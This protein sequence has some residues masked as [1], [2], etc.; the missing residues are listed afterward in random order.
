MVKWTL[1]FG[2][3]LLALL[4]FEPVRAGD[5]AREIDFA[6]EIRPLLADHCFHC[7]GN[8]EGS[9]KAHLRLDT[10]EGLFSRHEDSFPVVP[11]K[12]AESEIWKRVTSTDPDEVMPPP[13]AHHTLTS[14]EL[15]KLR[16]W[17][18]GGAPYR[19]H[20]A[21]RA[22]VRPELPRVEESGWP[23]N[24]VDAFLLTKLEA[25]HLK[26]SPDAPKELLLR[27]VTFDLTGLPPTPAEVDAFLTDDSPGAYE[28]VVDRLLVSPR[29]G[30]RMARPW[31][32][33]VR[34]GDTQG[35]H[36]DD[37]RSI[38]P[39]RDWVVRAFNQNLPFDQFTIWQ[40]AGDLLPQATR[41]QLIASGYN[42]CNLTTNEAGSVEAELL[43]R[44]ALD[45]TTTTVS[46]WMGLTA[47]C[48][49]CHDHKFDPLSQKEFYSLY[50]FFHSAAEPAM[51]EHAQP[52]PP[53][54]R[55]TTPEQE[56]RE[57]EMAAE[58]AKIEAEMKSDL[59]SLP[60]RDPA[61]QS[62]RARSGSG[63]DRLDGR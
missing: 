60:Y 46:L 6:R 30:E 8:D 61:L 5:S 33:A 20:W 62:P 37:E 18:E 63:G 44:Y 45:R 29:F 1:R 14:S 48:A 42:R 11:G 38:W 39:Y 31:L 10:A 22:P 27:R 7:H 40:I 58:S 56:K 52:T 9:R 26:P 3:L 54:L 12:L 53:V 23:R 4:G 51:E 41:D 34:Y 55:L 16:R 25:E 59:A 28:R 36:Y 57:Q 2:T 43:H 24:P 17:I 32:D 49:V 19:E 13:K 50:A 47:E 15:E 35:M 21:F